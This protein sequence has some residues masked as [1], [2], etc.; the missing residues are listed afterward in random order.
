MPEETTQAVIPSPVSTAVAVVPA[1]PSLS[2]K[3]K[4][5][6]QLNLAV[7]ELPDRDMERLLIGGDIGML[8][9]PVK[10]AY[11]AYQCERM[12]LD[13]MSRPLEF[14][15]LSGKTVLYMKKEGAEMLRVKHGV[16]VEVLK[17]ETTP[18]MYTV[19]VR[20]TMPDGR[21]EDN[22]AALPIVKGDL[23]ILKMKCYSKALRRVTLAI[24]GC[25]FT[26]ERVI[27]AEFAGVAV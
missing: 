21:H 6:A 10:L 26:D 27:D 11:Y 25:G 24:T 13:P 4:L 14:L 19:W 9:P 22:I 1:S 17:D 15:S 16:S 3:E 20:A 2:R 8:S 7:S 5:A 18:E 12:G 23:G